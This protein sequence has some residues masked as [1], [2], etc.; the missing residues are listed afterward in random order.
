[1]SSPALAFINEFKD[2]TVSDIK[3][4]F[5][6]QNCE[7]GSQLET[8]FNA[9][10]NDIMNDNVSERFVKNF[11][12]DQ[13]N[14]IEQTVRL[15]K[16]MYGPIINGRVLHD[17]MENLLTEKKADNTHVDLEDLKEYQ[18]MIYFYFKRYQINL[19]DKEDRKIFTDKILTTFDVCGSNLTP[20]T[21]QANTN[22]D[23]AGLS[24][25]MTKFQYEYIVNNDSLNEQ[26]AD[27]N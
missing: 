10:N 8:Y 17:I 14:G 11:T 4:L 7:D 24:R 2:H 20:P 19:D 6:L 1:M 26:R 12:L 25:F 9:V 16:H 18:E 15:I 21:E 22:D 5:D 27:N 3:T 13:T 23:D